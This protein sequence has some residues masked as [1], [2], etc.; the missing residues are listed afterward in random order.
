MCPDPILSD[1]GKD[2]FDIRAGRSVDK[3]GTPTP[4]GVTEGSDN[5]DDP[6]YIS[7]T[8]MGWFPGY[9][10]N[11]E[12]GERLNIAF[13]EDSWL[14]A[15]NGRDMIWNPTSDFWDF[16]DPI[17]LKPL[18][19]G[20]HYIYV[21]A[22][23]V[24]KYQENG[25]YF[26]EYD[27][28]AYDAGRRLREGIARNL[29]DLERPILYS[30]CMWVNIPLAVFGEEWMS[31]DAT[32][33]IRMIKPYDQYFST[34]LN[35]TIYYPDSS[36]FIPGDEITY[37]NFYPAYRFSTEGLA[38]VTDD[39]EKAKTDM[40]LI[41]I[42]PNPYYGYSP[43]ETN[44]L[45]NRVKITNLPQR[46]TVSIYNMSGTLIRQYTKDDSKTS[47]DWDLKNYA[48]IPIASGIYLIYVNAEGIGERVIKWFGSLRPVDLNA[49]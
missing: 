47:I 5:P 33:K 3:N 9:A 34:P 44:Q 18:F 14:V 23:T 15:Q 32:V 7:A 25:V 12:T 40:D 21:F 43:Y 30:S 26:P 45:D 39:Y 27:M 22:H 16:T 24:N 2:Q 49:F 46:C 6:N 31:N 4:E 38:T 28:P 1:G 19:G 8:G 41:N 11:V 42:V 13:S 35:D 10:I 17:N 37:N 36:Y 20:K 29:N 48:G